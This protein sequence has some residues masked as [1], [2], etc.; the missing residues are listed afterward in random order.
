MFKQKIKKAF[1]R[2]IK[3]K[4]FKGI[5]TLFMLFILLDLFFPFKI[6]PNYS[7]LIT[8]SD[9]KLLHAFLNK[10]DKW[11]M[12][13]ELTEITPTLEKA[14]VFKEDRWFR[15]H[16]GVN[17][18]AV[19]R[20][21]ARNIF[22]GRRTS[23]AST[24]T[25]QVVRLLH[26]Q[27]RTYFNKFIEIFRAIQLEFHYSKD[28]ILQFYINLVPYGSNIEGLKSAS[29]L[30]FQKSP[31]VLSLAEVTA[32]TIIPNRPSSLRLGTNNAF[33]LQER[34]RWLQNFKDAAL[35][36]KQDIEDAIN[37]PLNVT[38]H[39]APHLAPHLS[40][41]LKQENPTQSII[42]TVLVRHKQLTIENIVQNYVSR[43]YAMNIHNAAVMVINNKT[44]Q[45]EA[46]IGSADFNNPIDGGQVDGIRAIRSPG[47]TLKPLLYATAFDKG[48]I[49]PKTAINDVPTNFG[50]F[51]PEN[52]DK[53]FHGKIT[54]EYALANSLNIPAVKM[55]K[56]IST[57]VL[58]D[59]LKKS[60][61]QTVKKNSSKLGLSLVLGGCGV[62]LE[63]LTNLFSAFANEGNFQKATYSLKSKETPRV[64]NEIISKESSYLITQ[65]LSQITRPDLPN[66]YDY[67]YRMPKIAWKTG[68][69][70]GK[71]D[72]W[73][74]GY[75]AHYTIGV[76]IGNFSGEGVPELSGANIATP[77]LFDIFNT[78]DYN[79]SS[80]WF[81]APENIA[82]R[83]VCAE[84][85]DVPNEFCTHQIVDYYI[86][87]VSK[88]TKCQ[89]AK[90]IF[91]SAD[92]KISYCSHCLPDDGAI[93]KLYPNY[94]PELLSWYESK[95]ILY[96]KIPPH[97]P[98]CER[99]FNTDAPQ[100]VYPVDGS[101]Y[102][103]AKNE[104]QKLMLNCQVGNEVKT[105]YWYINDKLLQK[106]SPNA[107]VF[108]TP[109][110][111]KIKISCSDDKGRNAD[112]YV[113]VIY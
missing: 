62:T 16:F 71:K 34:N 18:F 89:H 37:E 8:D 55:L 54:I 58:V 19:M 74:I 57:P 61:F 31:N 24:I 108:F 112:I 33:I 1:Q 73:S 87:S 98:K 76:W 99:V 32:L 38:R 93:K 92:Q 100:I 25:M 49:T 40:L 48:I 85:G 20:A 6:N 3:T 68:T 51:E 80:K 110:A 63:E 97:N 83:K 43:L 44:H 13:T 84:S 113:K 4:F 17:P 59:K 42:K 75:N 50:G 39:E 41:R 10:T 103:L 47:S 91:I 30:Y 9:G 7:T 53:L 77:L 45:V 109:Q 52:F 27:K 15:W 21:G 105:V 5:A 70:F 23:G 95:H 72:A 56:E 22:T 90:Y 96:E 60:D 67:T 29:I 64:K 12:E 69:S 46:Y 102:F 78:V 14:I 82:Y 65:I 11:R 104:N 79:S 111:G 106:A 107:E 81:K 35:F 2:I 66:N 101:E 28:E 26:P 88:M 86:P 94:A 36:N